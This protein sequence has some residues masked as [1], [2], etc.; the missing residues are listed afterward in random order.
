[1]PP[2]LVDSLLVQVTGEGASDPKYE[3]LVRD[4]PLHKGSVLLHPSYEAGKASFEAYSAEAGY[5]H[6]AF[7][8]SRM[9]V[10]LSRYAATVIVRYDTGPKHYFG[11]VTFGPGI[12]DTTV[13]ARFPSFKQGDTFD[14]RK[15]L[16]LQTDLSTT[17]YFTKVEINRADENEALRQVPIRVDLAGA[18]KIRLTGGVGYGTDEGARVRGLIEW[19]RLNAHGHPPS[20][21]LHYR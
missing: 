19:R 11:D 5:L 1:G 10:D 18:K 20:L 15:L 21:D 2:L 7:L 3:A 12:I 14:F 16:T 17:G 9:E 6:P 4:F 8:E 13:L